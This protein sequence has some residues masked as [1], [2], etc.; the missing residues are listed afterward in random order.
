MDLVAAEAEEE[1]KEEQQ[2]KK[3]PKDPWQDF[4]MPYQVATIEEYQ[5]SAYFTDP[6]QVEWLWSRMHAKCQITTPSGKMLRENKASIANELDALMIGREELHYR[7]EDFQPDQATPWKIHTVESRGFFAM[8][9][10]LMK[11]KTLK[12]ASK[13]N[14]LN[15]LLGMCNMLSRLFLE[16]EAIMGIITDPMNVTHH[17]ELAFEGTG[18]CRG[19]WQNLIQH[20]PGCVDQWKRLSTSIWMGHCIT[21]SLDSAT[22]SDIVYFLVWVYCHPASKA[23]GQR[24]LHCLVLETLP[25]VVNKLG[26]WL[27]RLA[28]QLSA[29]NLTALPVLRSKT[30]HATRQA[31]PVNKM[32][33][34]YRLRK[35]KLHRRRV[36]LTHEDLSLQGTRMMHY[37]SYLDSLLHYQALNST[38]QGQCQLCV[39][40]DPSSYGGKEIL[41]GAIYS[42]ALDKGAWMLNQQMGHVMM[43]QLH[44]SLLPYAKSSTLGRIPGYNEMRALSAALRGV[45][46]SLT[47]FVVPEG[48]IARPLESTEYRIQDEEGLWWILDEK[49][50]KATPQKPR[51]LDLGSIPLLVSI[52]DQGPVNLAA[53]NFLMF[54]SSALMLHAQFD[55]F[56]RAWNDLKNAMKK[57]ISGAWRVVLQLTLVANV[58]YGPFGSSQW[59][60]KKKAKLEEFLATRTIDSSSWEKY[61]HLICQE[62]RKPEPTSR[63]DKEALF[64]SLQYLPSFVDKGPLIKLMR[65]FSFFESMLFWDGQFWVNK[66]ILAEQLFAEDPEQKDDA[67]PDQQLPQESNPQR[68]LQELKKKQGTWKLAPSLITERS[69]TIKDAILATGKATWKVHAAKARE[70]LSPLQVTQFNQSCSGDRFWAHELEELVASSLWNFKTLQHLFPE[71]CIHKDALLY[72]TDL[73]DKVLEARAQ[74]LAS[75]N[76]VPPHCYSHALSKNPVVAQEARKKAVAQWSIPLEAEAAHSRGALPEAAQ[77]RGPL[78]K[79]WTKW[80]GG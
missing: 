74:S 9:L 62:M 20:S 27:S 14:A 50:G 33:L 8:L 21:S 12:A 29:K 25:R 42:P 2:P 71:W 56:H 78:V 45:G 28:V 40:W 4:Q 77:S 1:R 37:E 49:T 26:G 57:S 64:T 53:L 22:F 72:H 76:E 30:G 65:W 59:F 18:V 47:D 39:S 17:V 13:L 35:E 60:F 24:L 36:A 6:E 58:S 69:L 10:W 79:P 48:L 19:A 46:L 75:M 52:S 51:S 23:R 80:C 44:E 31:D 11:N 41:V 5:V 68:E 61:E 38:F 34:M 3:V 67:E 16:A 15:L 54:S 55:P 43:S 63:E 7:G 73:F 32:I 70:V 66:M